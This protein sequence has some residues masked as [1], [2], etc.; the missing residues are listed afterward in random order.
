LA[1]WLHYFASIET[2]SLATVAPS[3]I[4]GLVV[5]QL[6]SEANHSLKL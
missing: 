2:V 6:T 4:D 1:I 3:L 5:L